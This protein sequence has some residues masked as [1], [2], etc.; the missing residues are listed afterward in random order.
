MK[1]SSLPAG[2][3]AIIFC[4]KLAISCYQP[5]RDSKKN[6]PEIEITDGDETSL[7]PASWYLS[8]SG[9]SSSE[10]VMLVA[11]AHMINVFV[12]ILGRL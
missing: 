6:Q 3:N 9:S 7:P 5:N 11:E 10:I 4:E 8:F 2:S 1:S 12:N